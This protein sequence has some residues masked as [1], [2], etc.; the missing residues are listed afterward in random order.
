MYEGKDSPEI[1]IVA[2]SFH[3]R[4]S[5]LSQEPADMLIMMMQKNYT[6][7]YGTIRNYTEIYG[8]IRNNTEL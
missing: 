1:V 8:T 7:L 3:L 5:L 6:E 4:V 2:V